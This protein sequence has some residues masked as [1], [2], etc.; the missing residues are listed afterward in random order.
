M[1]PTFLSQIFK[2][3]QRG[4]AREESYYHILKKLIDDYSD[5]VKKKFHVTILPKKTVF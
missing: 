1:L 2:T 3:Y 5:S 4:D